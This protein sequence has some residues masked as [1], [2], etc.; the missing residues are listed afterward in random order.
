MFTRRLEKARE[1]SKNGEQN[2]EPTRGASTVELQAKER[3][4]CSRK[5]QRALR[6]T[7]GAERAEGTE[8]AEDRT[9]SRGRMQEEKIFLPRMTQRGT[10]A[11]EGDA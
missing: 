1:D 10:A 5:S 4:I 8:R 11:T 2:G 9:I 7:E 3:R 6:G